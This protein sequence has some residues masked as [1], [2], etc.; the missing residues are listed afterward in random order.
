MY[1]RAK[2]KEG[3]SFD[4][5][6]DPIGSV[7]YDGAHYFMAIDQEGSPRFISRRPSVKG[8]F[9]DRTEKLPHLAST[10]FPAL[11]GNVYA[12]ELI[13][14]GHSTGPDAMESHPAVSGILNSLTPRALETQR[15][16]GPIRA[17]LLDV[18]HPSLPTYKDKIEH[19]KQVEHAFGNTNL[20]R[21]PEFKIGLDQ[22]QKLVQETKS[23]GREGV[24]ITSLSKPENENFRIKVKH[25]QHY[26]L[27]VCGIQQEFDIAGKPK[28][29][30]GA[31]LLEDATGRMVGK[32]G[33]G[34]SREL[35]LE[36]WNNQS[37]WLGSL[38]QVI[39]MEPT[40]SQVRS[41]RYNGLADGDLDTV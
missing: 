14:T 38:I 28:E 39:A 1:E 13:H 33:T 17:I 31:F 35:R 22:I 15:N 34:F 30:M 19:L 37:K 12:V 16:T 7:K 40:A 5:L 24:I 26:N 8:H 6:P 21:V 27:K 23:Q 41:A 9:P 25:L 11:A 3:V 2:Y 36:I 32:V 4:N 10:K 29:S 20:L 18:K